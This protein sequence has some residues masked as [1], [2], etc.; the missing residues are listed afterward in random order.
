MVILLAV[1]QMHDKNICLLDADYYL[2][3]KQLHRS[4]NLSDNNCF[5]RICIFVCLIKYV[6]LRQ[7]HEIWIHELCQK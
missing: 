3:Y 6:L 2:S 4:V 5:N 7:I 1:K